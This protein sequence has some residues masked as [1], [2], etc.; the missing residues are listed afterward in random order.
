MLVEP[1]WT[2]S[3]HQKLN[4]KAFLVEDNFVYVAEKERYLSKIDLLS[5]SYVWS[6]KISNTWG[7]LYLYRSCLYYLEQ[8][9]QLLVIEKDTGEIIKTKELRCSHLGYIIASD[10]LLITGGWRGYSHLKGY[11]FNTLDLLW[12]KKVADSKNLVDYSVPSISSNNLLLTANHTTQLMEA[13]E[14]NSG[15]VKSS[16]FL[17]DGFR[18][19]D[20][21]SSFQII[22]ERVIFTSLKGKLYILNTDLELL[23]I[24]VLN[25]DSILTMLPYFYDD[26]LIYE[27]SHGNFVFYDRTNK[28]TIS[29]VRLEN[30]SRI[31]IFA[32]RLKDKIFILGG[33]LG[34]LKVVEETGNE[35]IKIKSD[36]RISTNI[37]AFEKLII[38]GNKSEVRV[39][40][41]RDC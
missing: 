34:Q 13:I 4:A 16:F 36:S 10:R 39:W 29:S 7:W 25:T 12:E 38:Y 5:S 8:S 15:S 35:I 27:E 18:C 24:E 33:S 40:Q 2:K 6:L 31:K 32:N 1:V 21:E 37:Y 23:Q 30:N 14:L 17:P 20:L 41:W 19:C 9:G 22:N 26:R 11:D 3:L 28:R